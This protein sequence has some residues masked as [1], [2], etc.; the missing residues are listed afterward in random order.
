MLRFRTS[1][2]NSSLASSLT[3]YLVD[4]VVLSAEPLR[5]LSAQHLGFYQSP[6]MRSRIDIQRVFIKI[7]FRCRSSVIPDCF[8]WSD[9]RV[10]TLIGMTNSTFCHQIL[11]CE[12]V[13]GGGREACHDSLSQ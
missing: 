9:S 7:G 12:K 8:I 11:G 4:E 3:A 10:A 6:A 5:A 2:L 13:T 1:S